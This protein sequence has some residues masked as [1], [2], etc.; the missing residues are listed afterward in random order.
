MKIEAI[1]IGHASVRMARP[2]RTAI[3]ETTHTE[4]A[5][6]EVCAEGLVG[7]GA[8]LT[9][10]PNQA[11]AVCSM[12]ADLSEDLTGRDARYVRAH[13]EDMW[14]RLNLTGQTGIGALAL[15]ALDTALWDLLAQQAGMPLYRLLGAAHAELPVYTQGGWLSYPVQQLVE[16]ALSYQEQGYRYYKMRVGS[17]DW[18][19]DVS[20]VERVREALDPAVHLLVDANQGWATPDALTAAR[21]LDDLGLYWIEEPVEASNVD[22]CARVAAAITTP[23]AAGETV[24]GAAGFRPL[25]EQQAAG[26]LMPDLQHC[27]GPSGFMRVAT[28]AD[29]ADLPISG[30]LFAQVSV[31]LLAACRNALIV[32]HMPGWWDDLF[33]RPLDISGGV[34]RPPQDPGIGFRFSE[35]TS[36]QLTTAW[37]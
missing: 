25:I 15:S 14:L 29:L 35:T 10:K 5:L 20:R 13:W 18:R 31:H 22:G 17:S 16:E 23:V 26:I 1:R 27:G 19:S 12:I 8:A 36:K 21:A 32:E 7:Q 4:N 3:H 28:Q 24:F 6:V 37:I 33:D 34:I 11:R 9:L 2:M 30:H